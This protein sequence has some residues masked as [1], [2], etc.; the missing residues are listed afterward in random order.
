MA[1]YIDI[2]HNTVRHF[3]VIKSHKCW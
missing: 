2:Q 1:K 3:R